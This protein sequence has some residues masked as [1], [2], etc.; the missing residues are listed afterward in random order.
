MTIGNGKIE[1]K[2]VSK[3]NV[4]FIPMLKKNFRSSSTRHSGL[5][6]IDSRRSRLFGIAGMTTLEGLLKKLT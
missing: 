1:S 4:K 5:S 6:G 3:F 2:Q